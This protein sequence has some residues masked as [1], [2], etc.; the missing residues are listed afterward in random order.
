MTSPKSPL[1]TWIV[2]GIL[3]SICMASEEASDVVKLTKSNFDDVISKEKLVFVKFFA[4]WCGHCQAMVNDFKDAASQLK[5]KAILADVDATVEE[6]L[7]KKYNV[8]GFPTLKMFVDG[9]M[10]TDYN[11][12]RDKESMIKFVERATV[13]SYIEI[14]DQEAFKKFM[15]DNEE[16]NILVGADLDDAS[17]RIFRKATFSLRDVMPDA[18]EF[19][20]ALSADS[21]MI[22][23]FKKG[24][25]YLLRYQ[26]D[27]AHVPVKYD[28]SSEE[29]IDKF[30]KTSAL[31]VFQ[32]FT[33]ENAELYTELSIPLVVGFF[34]NCEVDNCKTLEKVAVAK[35]D[36]TKVAFAWVNNDTLGSFQEYVGLQDAVIPICAYAF[37]TDARYILPEDFTFSEENLGAWVDDIVAGKVAP[38]RKSQ[39]IPET[40]EGP[41]HIVVGDSWNTDVENAGKDVFIAQIAD[42]CGHCAALKP[43]MRKVADELDKA[44]VKHIRFAQMDATEN[45]APEKYKARGFPTIHF[46]PAGA[47]KG[48]DFDGGR[49]SKEIIEWLKEK[50]SKG[51]EFDTK[52]LGEDPKPDEVDD[53]DEMIDDEDDMVDEGEDMND[54]DELELDDGPLDDAEDYDEEDDGRDDVE[55]EEE[56]DESDLAD[57]NHE[58]DGVD[59]EEL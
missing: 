22:D 30:V 27:G 51:F 52:G 36:A 18:I 11:G 12:G 4:P 39:P 53:D 50:S 29:P 21:V 59:K 1:A 47:G 6:E 24:D 33:Q 43:I 31:P 49:S 34:T 15:T 48:I 9:E 13:P 26:A 3:Y 46:F 40:Q 57:E 14:A 25:I 54:I 7:A 17:M 55:H 41:V 32:E 8:D 20:Y 23:G 37:E 56:Y 35:S 38:T 10:L 44:G 58:M 2:F 45:D 5:G 16:K 28:V 42:W 19:A